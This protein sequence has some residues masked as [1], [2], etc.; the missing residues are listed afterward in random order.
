MV[1]GRVFSG[2]GVDCINGYGCGTASTAVKE[3]AGRQRQR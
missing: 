1:N 2:E 3:V